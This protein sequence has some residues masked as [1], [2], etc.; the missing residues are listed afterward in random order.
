[1]GALELDPYEITRRASGDT[2]SAN[3]RQLGSLD[4]LDYTISQLTWPLV[5]RSIRVT[6]DYTGWYSLANLHGHWSLGQLGDYTGWYI[7]AILHG[8]FGSDLHPGPL[9]L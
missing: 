8:Q 9:G 1:M 7:L 6:L 4:T 3:L 2:W 5:I